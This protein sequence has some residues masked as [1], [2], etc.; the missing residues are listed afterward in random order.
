ML[1]SFGVCMLS[2][3]AWQDAVPAAEAGEAKPPRF[4]VTKEQVAAIEAVLKDA[5]VTT[6]Y[7]AELFE[8]TPGSRAEY[9]L[10]GD[11]VARPIIPAGKGDLDFLPLGT[12]YLTVSKSVYIQW[13]GAAASTLHYYGPFY[14]NKIK[15]LGIDFREAAP[16]YEGFKADQALLRKQAVFESKDDAKDTKA[17]SPEACQAAQRI[18]ARV[19]F[20]FRT[21]SEVLEL[22]GDPATVS[23]YGEAAEKGL[24]SPLVYVFDTGF[25]GLQYTIGFDGEGRVSRVQVDSRN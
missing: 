21:K 10:R 11:V 6:N 22:L 2:L 24:S 13:D 1:T 12:A 23:D 16:P 17:S 18:F 25:G 5:P 14:G 8:L 15:K 7:L 3:F 20:L 4:V 19:P 9:R